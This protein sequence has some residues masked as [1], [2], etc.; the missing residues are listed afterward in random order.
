MRGAEPVTE[1]LKAI[2]HVDH[3][4]SG[5][6]HPRVALMAIQIVTMGDGRQRLVL[7]P[8]HWIVLRSPFPL[9]R[10]RA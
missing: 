8:R 4:T 10:F 1:R 9:R 2:A 6:T 3:G 7:R 5:L